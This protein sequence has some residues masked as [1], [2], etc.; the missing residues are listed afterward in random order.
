VAAAMTWSVKDA[1]VGYSKKDQ[2]TMMLHG[3]LSDGAEK[4]S[5]AEEDPPNLGTTSKCHVLI[6]YVLACVCM[7]VC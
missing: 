7:Y 4:P 5:S 2:M 6:R 3:H 1:L